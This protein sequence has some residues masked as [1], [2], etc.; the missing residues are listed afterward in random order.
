VIDVAGGSSTPF[1]E[2][3]ESEGAAARRAV[4]AMLEAGLLDRVL[5]QADAGELR[6]TGEGGFL[7]EMVKRVLEAGLAAELTD[8]LGYERHDPAGNGSGNSRNGSTPKQLGTEVGDVDLAT[9]RDRN[10]TF[11]PQLVGKG[12]RRLDG[13]SEMIISLYAKGMTVRDIQHHLAST[14]GSQLSHETISNITDAVAEEVKAW[15]AR[16]LEPIYPIVYLDALVVKVRDSHAVRNK[17]AHIAVGVDTDGIKHVLGI[18]VQAVEGAKFWLG[19]LAELRNRGVADV[20]I[21][22]CDGLTGFPDAIEATWPRAVVQTCTVHLIRASMRFVSY[23]DRKA[24]AAA[25]RPIYTAATE[26]AAAAEL[27]AFEGSRWG[28]KY[29][30]AVTTWRSAWERFVPFLEFAPEVRKI[31]Y[32]TNSIESLNYQ[33]RK[34]IKNRGHFPN[35][36]AV[37]KLL[38]L[39]IRDIEAKRAAERAKEAG[40]PKSQPRKAPGR[41]VEGQVVQGWNQALGALSIA[42]GDRLNP[43]L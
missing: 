17:A 40:T 16:P 13:L 30:A 39:A 2:P 26:T 32:T 41:L 21:V 43:N 1:G 25:L 10:A 9:P 33:L 27:D 22:C 15:Q 29:P 14:L 34:I 8:H 20:L 19:V 42:F 24:V 23:A 7:P 5:E 36:E 28:K 31:I 4:D 11:D 38:W 18:W 12:Q 37:V 35:D 6:L 3:A